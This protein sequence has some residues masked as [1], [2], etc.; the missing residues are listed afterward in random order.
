M[1]FQKAAEME[2]GMVAAMAEDLVDRKD[3]TWAGS[4]DYTEEL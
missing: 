4:K 3:L 1:V 2:F